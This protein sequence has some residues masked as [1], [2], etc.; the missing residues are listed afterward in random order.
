MDNK[1]SFQNGLKLIKDNM[2]SIKKN[3]FIT[4]LVWGN[5]ILLDN[6]SIIAFMN[7]EDNGKIIE[8]IC[9]LESYNYVC[10]GYVLSTRINK[11]AWK[12]ETK[13]FITKEK[14]EASLYC[15]SCKET[16]DFN[17]N[18]YYTINKNST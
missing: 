15:N 9:V 17:K 12:L 3:L 5:E 16:I 18:K 1:Q 8:S 4:Y 7:V 6:E 13:C 14:I 11:E 10:M 2:D